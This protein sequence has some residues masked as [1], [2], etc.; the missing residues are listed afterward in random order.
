[1][2]AVAAGTCA[3]RPEE[4]KGIAVLRVAHGRIRSWAVVLGAGPGP[5][6]PGDTMTEH[7]H[8][9]ALIRARMARTGERFADLRTEG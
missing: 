7:K 3:A 9:K 5:A 1:M 6:A 2:G 4:P 8:Q